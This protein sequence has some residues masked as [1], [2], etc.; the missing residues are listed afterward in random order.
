MPTTKTRRRRVPASAEIAEHPKT[1]AAR[2]VAANG[3][4]E[5]RRMYTKGWTT[6]ASDA[7]LEE[8]GLFEDDAFQDGYLDRAAEREKWH[9]SRCGDH[10][11]CD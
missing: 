8:A 3:I 11:Y 7:Y 5:Y 10:Q 2:Y 6:K 4:E 1:A 9:L